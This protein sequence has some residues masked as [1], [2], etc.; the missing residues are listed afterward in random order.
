MIVAT[1]DPRLASR[2]FLVG[3]LFSVILYELFTGESMPSRFGGWV[4][5]RE[6]SPRSYWAF[7]WLKV[8]LLVFLVARIGLDYGWNW[9]REIFQ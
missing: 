9:F 3:L 5:T 2:L 6:R 8:A 7:L 4:G 1:Q